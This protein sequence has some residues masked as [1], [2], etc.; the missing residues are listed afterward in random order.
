MGVAGAQKSVGV[1]RGVRICRSCALR[2]TQQGLGHAL[3]RLGPLGA[4]RRG[5][6]KVLDHPP[7]LGVS[8]RLRPALG[9]FR[10]RRLPGGV[11]MILG[12]APTPSAAI[13]A[14]GATLP[15]LAG[16][17]SLRVAD[18]PRLVCA[19]PR[20]SSGVSREREP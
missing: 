17:T 7:L 2:V 15:L 10:R 18:A 4:A 9:P 14:A 5:A 12:A 16:A 19:R 3:G 20:R 8:R 13:I 6:E 11:A 1:Q